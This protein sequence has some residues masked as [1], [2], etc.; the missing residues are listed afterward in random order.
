[1]RAFL[2]LVCVGVA[3][4]AILNTKV[5]NIP[6]QMLPDDIQ[7]D[8]ESVDAALNILDGKQCELL[9]KIIG[10]KPDQMEPDMN[11][12]KLELRTNDS[13]TTYEISTAAEDI[14][15]S[16]FVNWNK[17]LAIFIHGFIDDPSLFAFSSINDAFLKEGK[18]I[19]ALDCS[20]YIRWLYLRS[21]TYVRFIGEKLGAVLAKMVQH[22]IKPEEIHLIGH[23]L[24]AQISAFAGK[25]FHELTNKKVGHITGLD[26]AGPCF[27]NVDSDLRLTKTDAQFVDVIHTNGGVYG[28]FEPLGHV[29]FYPNGGKKQHLC[30]TQACSHCRAVVYYAESVVNPE[31]FPAVQCDNWE[32]FRN[33]KC[34][35]VISYMGYPTKSTATGLFY[36]RTGN[37]SPYGLG[38]KG[39]KYKKGILNVAEPTHDME[40]QGNYDEYGI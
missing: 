22:G 30:L 12:L 38:E 34:S 23:S 7:E 36:L 21:T 14:P 17:E 33:G 28:L 40:N 25:T 1:M 10:M 18:T 9:K 5:P 37:S 3:S 35:D 2:V 39:L 26:P 32:E 31:A 20:P 4:A 19:L 11:K 27:T 29:D 15:K 13:T 16:E 6:M 8:D 24:G